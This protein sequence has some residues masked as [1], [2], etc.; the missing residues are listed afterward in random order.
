[1]QIGSHQNF[2][3]KS[4]WHNSSLTVTCRIPSFFPLQLIKKLIEGVRAPTSTCAYWGGE[5]IS[6]VTTV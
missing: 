6:T 3:T 2:G 5:L 4:F 1:M